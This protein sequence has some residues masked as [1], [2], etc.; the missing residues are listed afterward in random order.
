M[1]TLSIRIPKSIHSEAKRLAEQEGI[2]LNQLISTALAEKVSALVTEDYL[3]S[4]AKR[5]EDQK[6]DKILELVPD[7]APEEGDEIDEAPNK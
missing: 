1:S 4:R 6:I 3:K 7:V 5:G 2:S